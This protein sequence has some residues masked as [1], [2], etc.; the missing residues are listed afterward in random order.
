LREALIA[1]SIDLIIDV[2][3]NRGQFALDARQ[4]GYRGEIISFEP[5]RAHKEN[6][7]ALA[8]KDGR[9]RI[10]PYALGSTTGEQ[11]LNVYRNDKFSSFHS[12]NAGATLSFGS[13]VEL[14]HTELV[15]V[16][17]IDDLSDELGLIPKRRAMLKTDTQGH[18]AAVLRGAQR[19][20]RHIRFVLSEAT[21]ASLYD[22]SSTW[23]E[24]AGLLLPLGFARS[25][26]FPIAYKPG[27]LALIELDCYFTR[28][29]SEF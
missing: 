28:E 6:L 21:V 25:G 17:T 13:M 14:D 27:T 3:A 8:K 18:D 5:L 2:G 22:G 12:I 11:K 20:L 7:E 19:A 10:L 9:W 1:H 26:M 15:Q 4:I 24:I 23:E 29:I 16:L